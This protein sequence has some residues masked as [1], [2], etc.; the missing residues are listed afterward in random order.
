MSQNPVWDV[1]FE[2]YFTSSIWTEI[3]SSLQT[4]CTPSAFGR[5]CLQPQL[6]APHLLPVC[7]DL[8]HPTDPGRRGSLPA[9]L[10]SES[11]A[12]RLQ[13]DILC[14]F[15]GIQCV[16]PVLIVK[17]PQKLVNDITKTHEKFSRCFIQSSQG[18]SY[19]YN[20]KIGILWFSRSWQFCSDCLF[21]LSSLLHMEP[22]YLL[23]HITH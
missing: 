18:S 19:W 6:A 1:K 20:W 2:I 13:S 16:H 17:Q 12:A 10:Q 21:I 8:Q 11:G 3:F 23:C 4:P 7:S 15:N 9:F 22:M 5:L 14:G